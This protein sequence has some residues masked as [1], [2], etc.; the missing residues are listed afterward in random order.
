M[1]TRAKPFISA[2]QHTIEYLNLTSAMQPLFHREDLPVPD[3]PTDPSKEYE[4]E[5]KEDTSVPNNELND[6]DRN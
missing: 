6:L 3:S 2:V 1:K 4:L 5:D